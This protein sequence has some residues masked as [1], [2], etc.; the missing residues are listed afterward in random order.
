MGIFGGSKTIVVSSTV[1]NMAGDEATRPDFLKNTIYGAVMSPYNPYLGETIVR[2]YLVGPGM[3]QRHF[4]K[5]AGRQLYPGLPTFKVTREAEVDE[6]I[7][8]PFIDTPVSP[9]GLVIDVQSANVQSGSYEFLVEQYVL[10]NNPENFN[11][12]YVSSFNGGTGEITIQWFGGG[13]VTFSASGFTKD[14]EYVTATY[15]HSI[16]SDTEALITGSTTVADVNAPSTTGYTQDS[17]V[18]TGIVNYPMT[19]DEQVITTYTGSEPPTLP[20]DTDV[21][22]TGLTD[23]VD[24]DGVTEAWSKTTYEGGDGNLEE[25]ISREHFLHW[26][27]YRQIY[28]DNTVVSIVVNENTPVAG[29]TET[30]LTRRIG[31]HLRPVFDHRID[32]QDTVLNRI[33]GGAQV[34]WYEIGTGEATLDA[35]LEDLA[36]SPTESEYFPYM[37]IRLDNVSITHADYDDTTGSGLYEK[38]NR[39]YRRATGGGERFSKLIDQI[40][41]NPDIGDIDYAFT[42]H[43]VALHVIEPACRKYMYKWF[44]GIMGWQDTTSTYIAAYKVL[45]DAYVAAW[46]TMNAWTY[47]QGDS[48]RSGYGDPQPPTPKLKD[49]KKTTIKLICADAQLKNLDMRITW[50]NVSETIG[51]SGAP[52]NPDTT[53]AGVKG[54]IWMQPGTDLTWTVTK[55]IYPSVY[56]DTQTVERLEMIWMTGSNTYDKLVMYGLVHRNYVYGGESVKTNGKEALADSEPTGFLIPLHYPTMQALGLKDAT[57]M[58]TANTFV[59]FNSYEIVKQKWYQGFLGMLII[60]IVIVVLAVIFAP[61]AG[62]GVGLLGSNAAVG[63]AMGLTG[64]AAI[65]AGAIAN[66]IVAIIVSKIITAGSVALFGDKIGAI[67][68]AVINLAITLGVGGVGFDNMSELGTASNIL[69]ISSAIANGYQGYVQ[70]AVAEIGDEMVENVEEY[71]KEMSDIEKKLIELR[72]GNDLNFDPLRLTDSVKGNA[73]STK[74]GYIT[75]SLDEFIHRTTMT[76]SDIVGIT[77]AVVNNFADLSLELPS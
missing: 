8:S 63:A 47:A 71:T 1:Y 10:A 55:G 44:K 39:A 24:F 21:T 15:Y 50:V 73:S 19:Y 46:V 53:V 48:G 72:G 60:I 33:Y 69:K 43:G 59:I 52:T 4:I 26:D 28:T 56:T 13:S 18:T 34:W 68:A 3:N 20:S 37:P 67:V 51:N 11:T 76:G 29:Q 22:T 61:A 58:A 30:I 70:G 2:N 32:T 7:V 64:T 49:L 62:G 35:L 77:L 5:W 40:E 66:A 75:E 65:V 9:A 27:E 41:D 12:D 17:S 42:H 6:A 74:G 38:T 36:V 57:Q 14:K 54:D 23:D 25:T 16:P 31:D 45:T